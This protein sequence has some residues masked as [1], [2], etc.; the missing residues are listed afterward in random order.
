MPSI[1]E[2]NSKLPAG[3]KAVLVGGSIHYV[4]RT[5][6][7]GKKVSLGTFTDGN[8]A[9]AKLAEFKLKKYATIQ[10]DELSSLSNE[11]E[12]AIAQKIARE[13]AQVAARQASLLTGDDALSMLRAAVEESGPHI[14][15]SGAQAVTISNDLGKTI[16]PADI[17]AIIYQE[18]WGMPPDINEA[19][20]MPGT[21]IN[22]Y[23]EDL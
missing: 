12:S 7:K 17:V 4:V 14:L 21:S 20:G 15:G 18:I 10:P 23:N 6:H 19:F 1:E 11:V 2:I 22:L 13:Q 16:I 9:I 3:I 5:S 8:V